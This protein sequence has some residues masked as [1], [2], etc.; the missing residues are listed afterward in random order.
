MAATSYRLVP[1]PA[2]AFEMG[3]PSTEAGREIRELQHTVTIRRPFLIGETPVTQRLWEL[4]MGANPAFHKDPER[5]VERISWRASVAFCNRLSELEGLG[6]VYEVSGRE[7]RWR[8][9]ADGFRLPTEAEWEYAARAG[10]RLPFSGSATALEVGWVQ[11]NSGGGT[12]PV[13]RKIPNGWGLLDMT[14]N[15]HEWVWDR[16]GGYPT[17]AVADPRG[18]ERGGARVY[19]GGCFESPPT[20]ARVAARLRIHPTYK[21]SAIGLRIARDGEAR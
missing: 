21:S 20:A 19:R 1:V 14:G 10:Q 13:G 8:E 2:G 9:G 4:T 11:D 5:P 16:Y 17:A 18:A 12:M 6:P 15:V 3:S 7:V